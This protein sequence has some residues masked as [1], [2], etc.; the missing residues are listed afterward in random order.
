MYT[1]ENESK[2]VILKF[3]SFAGRDGSFHNYSFLQYQFTGGERKI[4]VKPHDN[5]TKSSR[6]FKPP[7]S[8]TKL[9]LKELVQNQYPKG[10]S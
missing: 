5:A 6:P 7:A 10:G 9:R 3:V 8:S 2:K 1:Q 4:K